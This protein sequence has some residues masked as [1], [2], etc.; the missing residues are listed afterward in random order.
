MGFNQLIR[1][2]PEQVRF[3]FLLV[4]SLSAIA[5]VAQGFSVGLLLPVLAFMDNE[6]LPQ[7][8]VWG[9]LGSTFDF[10]RLSVNLPNLLI[11]TLVVTV[12]AQLLI[13]IQGRAAIRL[14]EGYAAQMREATFRSLV[15]ADVT[16]L[17]KAGVGES[18]NVLT[19]EI[20]QAASAFHAAIQ[21][22]ALLTV[23]AAYV[24]LLVLISW[25]MSLV[26]MAMVIVSS[27]LVQYQIRRARGLGRLLV[28][29]RGRIQQFTMER[30]EGIRLVKLKAME[31]DE[32]RSFGDLTG[33]LQHL[34]TRRDTGRAQI[35][36][37]MEPTL[38]AAGL[39]V[40]YLSFEVLGVSLVQLAV[41]LYVLVRLAP[42]AMSLNQF[43]HLISAGVGSL[44][45]I[46][47]RIS[48]S[49]EETT[50]AS[51]TRAFQAPERGIFLL[52]VSRA[53]APNH[54]VLQHVTFT[55]PKTGLTAIVGPSGAGKSTLL[56]LLVR[57]ADPDEGQIL[58]DDVDLKEFD[59]T[60]LRRNIGYVS[61][62]VM[63]F[64]GPIMANLKY[65][66]QNATEAD[67]QEAARRTNAHQFITALPSGYDTMMGYRG[68][69]LSGGEGQRLALAWAL[70]GNP[71]ILL[72]DEV[73]KNQDAESARL[74]RETIRDIARE[75][76]VVVSTHDHA[77]IQMA[78][79]VVVLE[80]G[81]VV[82][83]G[84]PKQLGGWEDLHTQFPE[85]EK[86]DE[87]PYVRR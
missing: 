55:I 84:H 86:G 42:L 77:L 47:R 61:Q 3:N 19:M 45:N 73:T 30:L 49:A 9:M 25:Q 78:D 8:K 74:I 2:I 67:V 5:A 75:R 29:L 87:Y 23:V 79:K 60:S 36:L 51:G 64:S 53:Y 76:P 22:T 1:S 65:G 40:L 66:H 16:Y 38:F 21:F 52:N 43:T 24:A 33:D 71:S 18:V 48:E 7:G 72:L 80:D 13:Y 27:L 54:P 35:R 20:Y 58:V 28:D 83:V 50:V 56:D 85:F 15:E 44:E 82:Q 12:L 59:L 10:L 11:V 81:K 62:D 70:V 31:E 26:G 32:Q 37:I 63:F 69:N 41:F 34:N 6:T 46:H 14:R 57:L 39:L 68:V 17:P 4:V